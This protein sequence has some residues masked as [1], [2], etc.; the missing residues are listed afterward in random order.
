MS[1]GSRIPAESSCSSLFLP[2]TRLF[3]L[4]GVRCGAFTPSLGLISQGLCFCLEASGECVAPCTIPVTRSHGT[5][6]SLSQQVYSL[7]VILPKT[8]LKERI[9]LP[10]K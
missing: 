3:V 7:V 4:M 5:I 6:S 2:V 1:C 9:S 8:P 10:C